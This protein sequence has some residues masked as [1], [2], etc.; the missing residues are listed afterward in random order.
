MLLTLMALPVALPAAAQG[1]AMTQAAVIAV[2]AGKAVMAGAMAAAAMAAIPTVRGIGS[3]INI[4]PA[5]KTDND[6]AHSKNRS[7]C[8]AAGI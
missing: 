3:G 1:G 4:C 8:T 2:A 7:S 5:G 6:G